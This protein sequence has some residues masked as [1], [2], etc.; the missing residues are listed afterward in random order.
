[1]RIRYRFERG[2]VPRPIVEVDLFT[3]SGK[4]I[5]TEA[6]VDSGAD[7]CLF[8]LSYARESETTIYPQLARRVSGI[9]G[10]MDVIP[11]VMSVRILGRRF[12]LRTH[13][14]EG[15]EQN[16]LGRDNFFRVFHVCFDEP[17]HELELRYRRGQKNR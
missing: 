5:E 9:S 4:I 16:L 12:L 14:V 15:L 17:N 13:F 2:R 10:R 1:M 8:D 3:D 11:G 6:L 7:T